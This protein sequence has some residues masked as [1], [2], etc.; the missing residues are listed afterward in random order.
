MTTITASSFVGS[1]QNR[2]VDGRQLSAPLRA[3]D[4]DGDGV[5]K[6]VDESRALFRAVDDFDKNGTRAS[7]NAAAAPVA[8][9]LAQVEQATR[10]A[11]G[12]TSGASTP[13]TAPTTSPSGSGRVV[14]EAKGTGYYP[15]NNAMEGGFVDKRGKPLQTL[16]DYVEA[17][18]KF[19]NDPSKWPPYVSI[20]LDKR[21]YANGVLNYGDKFRIPELER[22]FGMPIEFRAVDTGGAFTGKGFSRV[23]ICTSSARDSV[24]ATV[25]GR[26]TLQRM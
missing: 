12:M 5:V 23:D 11:R 16:N 15:A 6:G 20:A 14:G 10:P 2:E 3:A 1:L 7:V 26:L 18:Q 9:A 24:D 17:R 22:R 25:N 4:L 21:L 19:P 8:R 13:T